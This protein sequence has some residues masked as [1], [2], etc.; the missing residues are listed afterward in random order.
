MGKREDHKA[1][2]RREIQLA[3]LDLLETAGADATTVARIAERAGISERTFFRYYDSKESAAVPG[4]SELLD[5]LL[6]RELVPGA[7]PAEILRELIDVCRA[8]FAYEVEQVEFKRISRLLLHEPRLLQAVFR[9]EQHLVNTLGS[10][11]EERGL[12]PGMQAQLVAEL[13]A[14]TWRVAWQCFARQESA[15]RSSNPAELFEQAVQN[16]AEITA[17]KAFGR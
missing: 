4:Q 17:P 10:A 14:C 16:L 8:Q 12:L 11:L 9:Q 1:A 2:T 6:A 7:S 15:G 5:T 3:T 13:I